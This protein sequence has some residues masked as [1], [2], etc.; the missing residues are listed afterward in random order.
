MFVQSLE[1][2]LVARISVDLQR[3][4]FVVLEEAKLAGV[5]QLRKYFIL[6]V[7]LEFDES[8]VMLK[9]ILVLTGLKLAGISEVLY[10]VIAIDLSVGPSINFEMREHAFQLFVI[11]IMS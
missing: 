6:H 8:V 3:G 2:L 5:G 11:N 4:F 7:F 9:A 1:V 10:F